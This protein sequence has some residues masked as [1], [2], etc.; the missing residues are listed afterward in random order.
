M[1]IESPG[2]DPL[3]DAIAGLPACEPDRRRA[4]RS[5]ARCHR[6]IDRNRWAKPSSAHAARPLS[7]RVLEPALVATVSAVYLFQVVWRALQLCGF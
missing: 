4:D 2:V 1:S 7:A 3:L 5:R 6:A